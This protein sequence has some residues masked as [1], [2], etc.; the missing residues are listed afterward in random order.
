MRYY[1]FVL[2]LPLV[3]GQWTRNFLTW[4][5]FN[6]TARSPV[7][8]EAV[9]EWQIEP[10]TLKRVSPEEKADI[11]IRLVRFNRDDLLGYAFGPPSG[12]IH[13]RADL[14]NEPYRLYGVIQHEFGHALGLKHD[15][16]PTSV[17]NP[18]FGGNNVSAHDLGV[19]RDLY[20]CV[21][22]S[23]TLLNGHTYLVFTGSRYRRW[24]RE[25]G[26]RTQGPT[27]L[28][29]SHI[30]VMYR[31]RSGRYILTSDRTFYEFDD[32]MH[33][34]DSGPLNRYFPFVT[35]P[36]NAVLAF[37]NDTTYVFSKRFVYEDGGRRHRIEEIFRPTPRTPVRGAYLDSLR[38]QLV[39]VDDTHEWFYDLDRTYGGRRNVCRTLLPL[40][41]PWT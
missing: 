8:E 12:D 36:V 26:H 23:V 25:T 28:L 35:G 14:E 17:M 18:V 16:H 11:R 20:K 4:S 19:L 29:L 38:R 24:D 3:M 1:L 9:A 41:P 22:D 27:P 30:D 39:L 13:V 21:Y 2:L 31:N 5:V 33:I 32:R 40:L 6:E 7:F 34:V 37:R 15:S 10:L